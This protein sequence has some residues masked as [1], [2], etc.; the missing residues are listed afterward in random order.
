MLK[1]GSFLDV[2]IIFLTTQLEYYSSSAKLPI[3][4][5]IHVWIIFDP[6]SSKRNLISSVCPEMVIWEQRVI[7]SGHTPFSANCWTKYKQV[8]QG[9]K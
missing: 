1:W 9:A 6:G 3:L 5:E 2:C 8:I 4:N 7:N